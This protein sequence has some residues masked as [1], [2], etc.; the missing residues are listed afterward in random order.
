M[1]RLDAMQVLLTVVDEGSL[2]AGSRKLRTPLPSVSRKV[3]ELERHLGTRLLIRTSRNVQL[4]DAG[5][6]YIDSA[7][8]IVAELKEAEVRASGEYQV[9]RGE[10]TI[11]ATLQLGRAVVA[12]LTYEFLEEYPEISLNLRLIDR[13]VDLVDE[14][15]D[16]AVRVGNLEDSSLYATKVGEGRIIT[17]ASSAY[18]ERMGRPARPED[19][20]NHDAVIFTRMNEATW[21][22]WRDGKRFEG[23]PRLRVRVN[24]PVSAIDATIRGLGLTRAFNFMIDDKLRD[25]NLVRILDEYDGGS[26]PLHLVYARQ[27]ML[28]VKIRAFLDWMAPRLRERLQTCAATGGGLI[29][30]EMPNS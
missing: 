9:P 3:T 17:C 21:V 22:Y 11:A 10:L 29:F 19:L 15:I 28:P 20:A 4:T 30:S 5:R 23:L 2:S 6:D 18:L 7:R 12:P 14:Q 1:D 24:S 8:H 27:G 16:V 25:G 26:L 13:A